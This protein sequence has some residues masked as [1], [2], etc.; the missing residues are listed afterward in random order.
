FAVRREHL[1]AVGGLAACSASHMARLAGKL[2]NH[3]REHGLRILVT[4]YAVATF[5]SAPPVA[6]VDE[7]DVW[8]CVSKFWLKTAITKGKTPHRESQA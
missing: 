2:C 3:A 8:Q 5:E 6:A 1:A 4:P 7:A